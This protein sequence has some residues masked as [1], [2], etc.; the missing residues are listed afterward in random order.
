MAPL[1]ALH[2]NEIATRLAS[3]D[4]WAR[5]ATRIV[6]MYRFANHR[7]TMAFA[8]AVAWIAHRM[9]HHPDLEVG[10]DRCTV[11]YTTHSAGGLTAK[12]FDSAAKV[13]ALF[14]A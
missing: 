3:L 12:D 6:K 13:D 1:N 9:D 5:D 2:D 10:Y 11:S 8:N 14:G 7:E 4:G